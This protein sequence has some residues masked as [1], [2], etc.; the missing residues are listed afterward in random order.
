MTSPENSSAI[1]KF[2]P[3]TGKLTTLVKIHSN[4]WG[5]QPLNVEQRC[6]LDLLLRDDIKLVSLMGQAGQENFTCLS[7]GSKKSF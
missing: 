1:G 6:A 2:H 5:I 4:I 7:G 3:S